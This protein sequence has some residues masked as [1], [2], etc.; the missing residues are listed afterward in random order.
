[1]A[2]ALIMGV[3]NLLLSDEGFGVHV[4]RE[5][6]KKYRIPPEVEVVDGGCVGFS[7]ADYLREKDLVLLVDVI[8]DKAP[9]GSYRVLSA[10]ELE[11][12]PTVGLNSCHQTSLIEA[13][14]FAEFAGLR[15]ERFKIF[16]AVPE[17]LSPGLELSP[18]LRKT[19]PVALK[20]LEE[21]LVSAGFRV[22]KGPCA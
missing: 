14:K 2:K 4:I 22:E 13:L 3:G 16:A 8:A 19:V 17:D 1:M 11:S 20:W 6:E 7:L 15:P 18:G 21:E 9:P 12:F 5:F 10:Q